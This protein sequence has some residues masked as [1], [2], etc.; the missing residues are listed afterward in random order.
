MRRIQGSRKT[1]RHSLC[2]SFLCYLSSYWVRRNC[3]FCQFLAHEPAVVSE[4]DD[5]VTGD[6]SRCAATFVCASIAHAVQVHGH[7]FSTL[8]QLH[9]QRRRV[10]HCQQ[11]HHCVAVRLHHGQPSCA[12]RRPKIMSMMV[13]KC[14]G[15][16]AWAQRFQKQGFGWERNS[17]VVGGRA[18]R[19]HDI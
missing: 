15:P 19:E 5:P 14:G 8:L 2:C 7:H 6:D 1:L 11:Q 3:Q 18:Y 16:A 17:A 4:H 13:Y 9:Q 10:V 12:L